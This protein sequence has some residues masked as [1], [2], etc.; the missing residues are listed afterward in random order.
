[1]SSRVP[2]PEQRRPEE[3]PAARRRRMPFFGSD[4]PFVA[5]TSRF[6]VIGGVSAVIDFGLFNVLHFQSGVGTLTAKTIAVAA[7]TLF[8]YWGNRYWAFA[9]RRMSGHRQDLPVFAALNVVGLLIALAVLGITRYW[10]GLTGP[11][12]LNLVGNGGGLVLATLFR[13]VTYRAWVFREH[14]EPQVQTVSAS[15]SWGQGRRSVR[16][17]VGAIG[18]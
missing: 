12:A 18:Q 6:A 16:R 17:R 10:L 11:L 5:Q 13:F 15:P 9:S 4:R 1:V 8:S 7:A 14:P 2:V 3:K